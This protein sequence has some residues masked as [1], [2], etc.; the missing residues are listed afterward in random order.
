M[1]EANQATVT[2]FRAV[3]LDWSKQNKRSFPW[4]G[5]KSP[6]RVLLSELLLQRTRGENVAPVYEAMVKRWPTAAHLARARPHS[7]AEMVR[8]L[9]LAKRAPLV[10][11]FARTVVRDF[12]GRIPNDLQQL[13][14][15]PAVGP[16]SAHAVQI[17]ARRHNLPLVDWVIAR[18]L[19]R[20]F[21]LAGGKR[22]NADKDLWA[23]AEQASRDGQARAVWLGVL[24]FA[25]AVCAPRPRC[26]DCPLQT[27]CAF[28]RKTVETLP[29]RRRTR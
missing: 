11:A 27:S 7:V 24:D 16:Y 15:L 29:T 12:S 28:Y 17:F 5:T 8:P 10:T 20:Y 4:R 19:R 3:M 22:P 21:G 6:Y 14:R 26:P 25:S 1:M 9:G 13:Q 18:V 23:L 2:T